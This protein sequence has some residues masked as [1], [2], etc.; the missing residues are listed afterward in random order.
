[1][2]IRAAKALAFP[3]RG[4]VPPEL[5]EQY[6]QIRGFP[7]ATEKLDHLVIK[8]EGRQKDATKHKHAADN[9]NDQCRVEPSQ[10]TE[11]SSSQNEQ[12][13]K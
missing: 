12:C 3:L 8:E 11:I 2:R 1:M 9:Q 6:I 10:T 4:H 5:C 7:N 13:D